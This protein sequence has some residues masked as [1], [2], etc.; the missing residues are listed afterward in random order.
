MYI[1]RWKLTLSLI[2]CALGLLYALPNAMGPQMQAWMESHMPAGLPGQKV[3]LGLDLRGGSHLLLQVDLDAVVA[4]RLN[5]LVD[6]T[7]QALRKA[8][9]GYKDLGVVNGGVKF[10]LRD[11]AQKDAALSA[12]RKLDT[13]IEASVAPGLDDANI[14]TATLTE[15]SLRDR[16]TKAMEQ[17]IEIVRRRV[18]ESGTREPSI[19]RQGDD[20]ILLQLPGVD[21]PEHMKQLLG[22]TAKLEFRFVDAN[23]PNVVPGSPVPAGNDVLADQTDPKRQWVVNRRVIVGGDTLTDAQPSFDQTGRAVVSFK[24]DSVGARRFGDAT[25]TGVGKLFAIV[26]DGKVISAPV[27][28]EPI[29][30]GSGQIS[31]NFTVESAQ[32]LA[33]LLR[34]GALPAPLTVLE[35]R[36]VGP[37]LGA[38][39]IHAGALSCAVGLVLVVIFMLV[40]YGR[41]G[42][43]ATIALIFNMIFIVGL[44]SALQATLTLPG[45]AGIVLTISAAVDANVLV[46]ERMREEI[47]LGRTA[48][49]AV[50][51]GYSRAI[52]AIVDANVTT[53]IAALMLFLFGTGPVK[54]FAVTLSIGIMTSLFSALVL[55]KLMVAFYLKRHRPKT[56]PI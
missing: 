41:F 40:T 22:Q 56:L 13:G 33:L 28:N 49:A 19:Q 29:L 5:A 2:V 53:L 46:F 24:F 37:G 55:T 17:S 44:L 45:I 26:L 35:E 4:E 7:R 39:S 15:A 36:T 34:A 23:M 31:G 25:K 10:A 1:P 6:E 47:R 3:N 42:V 51:A 50:D 54:G 52:S 8:E 14:V 27:I 16:K 21:N 30:G 38:D 18:D 12:V 20:R 48:Y 9:V 11:A 43:Y 32:N